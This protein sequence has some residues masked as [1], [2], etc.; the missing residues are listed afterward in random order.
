MANWRSIRKTASLIH[1]SYDGTFSNN[2]FARDFR[3]STHPEFHLSLDL[4][5]NLHTRPPTT[6]SCE[7]ARDLADGR[8]AKLELLQIDED[9]VMTGIARALRSF[10]SAPREWRLTVHLE[11]PHDFLVKPEVSLHGDSST[12]FL[13]VV[14]I[15][16]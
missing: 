6:N 14:T 1:V 8:I 5:G 3:L 12:L 2:L 11:G 4:N 15:D 13:Y 16:H 9:Q 7:D 10:A